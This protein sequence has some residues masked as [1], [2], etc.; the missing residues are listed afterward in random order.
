M[1]VRKSVDGGE[2]ANDILVADIMESAEGGA[3]S[4]NADEAEN[5]RSAD[6]VRRGSLNASYYNVMRCH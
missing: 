4:Q 2:V 6:V 1:H 3:G 5:A